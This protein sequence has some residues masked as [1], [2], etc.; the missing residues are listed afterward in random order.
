MHTSV[1]VKLSMTDTNKI[2][3]CN[4][5]KNQS[6]S[7]W[8]AKEGNDWTGGRSRTEEHISNEEVYVKPGRKNHRGTPNQR[9][10]ER[11]ARQ[12]VQNRVPR[13]K[14]RRNEGK[15]RFNSSLGF[16]GEG[17]VTYYDCKF[18]KQCKSMR[19]WHSRAKTGGKQRIDKAKRDA[20]KEKKSSWVLCDKPLSECDLPGHGHARK[21]RN[22]HTPPISKIVGCSSSVAL[23]R[24]EEEE[25]VFITIKDEKHE[26]QTPTEAKAIVKCNTRA[27][28]E[29]DE[30]DHQPTREELEAVA[31][32]A[33]EARCYGVLAT[34][35]LSKK[36]SWQTA[37]RAVIATASLKG[38]NNSAANMLGVVETFNLSM[39]ATLQHRLIDSRARASC[40][41]TAGRVLTA[42]C[43]LD[44][45]PISQDESDIVAAVNSYEQAQ[46]YSMLMLHES[47]QKIAYALGLAV[48]VALRAGCEE[49]VKRAM[50]HL[51][52]RGVNER[53]QRSAR[54]LITG[55]QSGSIVRTAIKSLSGVAET[56]S[57]AYARLVVCLS[58]AWIEGSMFNGGTAPS[59]IHWLVRTIAHYQTARNGWKGFMCHALYNMYIHAVGAKMLLLDVYQA[60]RELLVKPDTCLGSMPVKTVAQ[61]DGFQF[62]RSNHVCVEKFGSRMYFAVEGVEPIVHRQCTHNEI[63]GMAG[64]VGKRLPIHM[65]QLSYDNVLAC[66]DDLCKQTL[67]KVLELIRKVWK[68][69]NYERW[70]H[71]FPPAKRDMFLKMRVEIYET[72]KNPRA[73]AFIKRELTLRNTDTDGEII[74]KDCR[75]IQ[76]CPVELSAQCGPFVRRLAKNVRRGLLPDGFGTKSTRCFAPEDIAAGRQIVY[77]CGLSGEKIGECFGLAIQCIS[78]MC[79]S[80]EQVVFLEDD[81]SRFDLHLTEGAF[82]YLDKL[83]TSKLPRAIAKALRRTNK[84]KGQT[85][86]GTKY[87]VPYTMQSGWPDT[88]CGDTLVNVGLKFHIHGVGGKWIAII[89]GDDSVTITTNRYLQKLGGIAGVESSYK[90]FGM[91]VEAQLRQNAF[92]VEFC[93]ARF[94]PAGETWVLMPK[95]GKMLAR[96][97][98]DMVDR[99]NNQRVEWLRGI[100]ATFDS[101]G[102]YDPLLAAMGERIREL[103]GLGPLRKST[104][105]YERWVDGTAVTT[106]DDVVD[107]YLHHYCMTQC[108]I[109]SVAAYLR[110][111]TIGQVMDHPTLVGMSKHDV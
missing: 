59:K 3:R 110:E 8:D 34:P 64:R 88:S 43:S 56:G 12:L 57:Q 72:S 47:W 55:T 7:H 94:M 69:M 33:V 45:R 74:E 73:S 65:S 42:L 95:A 53:I 20:C 97:G 99:P 2:T 89:C 13:H 100:A 37:L 78:S 26:S 14:F 32:K 108:D 49:L 104:N 92:D 35:D 50:V 67:P 79:D 11:R 63:V 77:T 82:T 106:S 62:A 103:C 70:A 51:I 83:Y 31:R 86:T 66:W 36:S 40:P 98:W 17:P 111:A 38:L 105:A 1:I 19:H 30:A 6:G 80:D 21:E 23:E 93:S 75:V 102:K 4:K 90:S 61:Q 44:K 107:Y 60:V 54:F 28:P 48:V 29:L 101:F 25:D 68:P 15:K 22:E 87:S 96:L 5:P 84:S 109:D 24:V 46:P 10:I 58:L 41:V 18:G 91:E 9:D 71:T 81:Q 85:I 16:P 27:T 39:R 76:G 52:R